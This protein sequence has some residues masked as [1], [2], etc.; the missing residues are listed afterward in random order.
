M[1]DVSTILPALGS[2]PG[3]EAVKA[4]LGGIDAGEPQIATFPDGSFYNYPPKG[5]SFFYTPPDLKL[6]RVD[7]YNPSNEPEPQSSRKRRKPTP[8]KPSP[9][10]IFNFPSTT[11]PI[12][13]PNKPAK[14]PSTAPTSIE[15]PSS[16]TVNSK[17]TAKQIVECFGEPRKKGGT[18]AW[19]ET[20]MEW[21]VEVLDQEGQVCSLGVMVELREGGGEGMDVWDRAP[22]WEWACLKVFRA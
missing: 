1:L 19:I 21:E 3:S 7:F 11:L 2:K 6:D 10:I 15:R 16:L 13:P 22:Q 5:L 14:T 8:Y 4:L 18:T 20:Y 17:T 9:V 12:P